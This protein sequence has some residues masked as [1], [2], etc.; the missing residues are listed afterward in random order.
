MNS[1][2]FMISSMSS[3]AIQK[4]SPSSFSMVDQAR[5]WFPII[6]ASSTLLALGLFASS[7]FDQRGSGGSTPP[8]Q[9]GCPAG[10][11]GPHASLEEN[12]TWHLVADI[13]RLREDLGI[14]QLREHLGI[15]R[16]LVFGG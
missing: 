13:E 5:V 12:T 14:E 7:F 2:R 3:V 9:R 15:E 6:D 11:P 10:D 4:E 1:L 16:W 8:P